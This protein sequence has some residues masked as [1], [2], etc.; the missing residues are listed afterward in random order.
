MKDYN[1]KFSLDCSN[2]SNDVHLN[3]ISKVKFRTFNLNNVFMIN[4]NKI[5]ACFYQHIFPQTPAA[6]LFYRIFLYYANLFF[7]LFDGR[8]TFNMQ[9]I[10]FDERAF[11][12]SLFRFYFIFCTV[13]SAYHLNSLLPHFYGT[14]DICYCC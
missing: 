14:W 6:Y 2:H 10:S 9:Q 11:R 7:V 3:D 8:L 4:K 12:L 1:I 13:S 5:K